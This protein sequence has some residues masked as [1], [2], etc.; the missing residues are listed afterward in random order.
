[1]LEYWNI[2]KAK[3]KK[4]IVHP[5]FHDSTIPLFLSFLFSAFSAA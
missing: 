2:D 1:M 5:L 3:K 4:I